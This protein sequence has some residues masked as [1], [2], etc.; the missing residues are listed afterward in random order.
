[1]YSGII[2]RPINEKLIAFGEIGLGGEI[3]NV[4]H[5]RQRILEAERMGFEDCII[6]KQSLS[7]INLKEFRINIT[8]VSTLRQAFSVIE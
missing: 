4:S 8:G 6:P 3:R 7:A 2:D 5:I 1:M